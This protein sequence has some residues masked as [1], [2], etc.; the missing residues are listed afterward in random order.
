MLTRTVINN[1]EVLV[2]IVIMVKMSVFPRQ[3]KE[4]EVRLAWILL[5]LKMTL[6]NNSD[7]RK[8]FVPLT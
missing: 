1:L 7:K 6:V 8:L 4:L 5:K 3:D 2:G